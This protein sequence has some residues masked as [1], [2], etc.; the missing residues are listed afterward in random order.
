VHDTPRPEGYGVQLSDVKTSVTLSG[1]D[2]S[3]YSVTKYDD[4]WTDVFYETAGGVNYLEVWT[5]TDI[6]DMGY[7]TSLDE[8]TYAPASGWSPSRTVEAIAGHTYVVWTSDDHYAKVYVTSV[9]PTS[10]TFS[11]AY[12]TAPGNRELKR[13]PDA[14]GVRAPLK[15]LASY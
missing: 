15:R 3:T 4:N 8:I 1:Y 11:W 6:Q 2:F 5:D 9:T 14:N 13:P 12:Q 10:I 7:T